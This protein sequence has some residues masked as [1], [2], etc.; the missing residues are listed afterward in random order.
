MDS[1][2]KK[3]RNAWSIVNVSIMHVFGVPEKE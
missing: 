2:I 3:V 1:C